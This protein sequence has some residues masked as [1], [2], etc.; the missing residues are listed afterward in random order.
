MYRT[1]YRYEFIANYKD[2]RFTKFLSLIPP[3]L[4]STGITSFNSMI[5]KGMGSILKKGS[6][7]ALNFAEKLSALSRGIFISSLVT[8]LFPSLA[9]EAAQEDKS[10]LIESIIQGINIIML[11]T[12]P[13]TI[14]MN[15]LSIPVVRLAFER[16]KFDEVATLMTASALI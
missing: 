2:P 4:V 13:T 1:D 7:S 15:V 12:I 8:A 10:A 14:A 9:K 3:V 6:I 5:D 16:D 11:V